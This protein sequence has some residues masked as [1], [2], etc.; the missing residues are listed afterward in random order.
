MRDAGQ[1]QAERLAALVRVEHP[2]AQ[3]RQPRLGAERGQAVPVEHV[4]HD[5]G[6]GVLLGVQ[7]LAARVRL[8][9]D[10]PQRVAGLERPQSGEVVV[11]LRALLCAAGVGRDAGWRA[12]ALGRRRARR[13][14]GGRR[15][16][17]PRR[18]TGR[19]DAGSRPRSARVA[20]ARG[21][22]AG[23]RDVAALP[24]RPRVRRR[25][26]RARVRC[27][28]RCAAVVRSAGFSSVQRNVTSPPAN[29]DSVAA[30]RSARPDSVPW[31]WCMTTSPRLTEQERERRGR[32]CCRNSGRRAP[33]RTA[34]PRSA[35]PSGVG[36]M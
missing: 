23:R 31:Q 36:R 18:G 5:V 33:S 15:A 6:A 10:A 3:L 2:A 35:M 28:A 7:A 30:S 4:R 34:S 26:N 22:G 25:C 27:R 8:P 19:A 20:R 32:G 21:A 17:R 9:G 11:A 12:A 1:P 24:C 13:S 16:R 29:A 14:R